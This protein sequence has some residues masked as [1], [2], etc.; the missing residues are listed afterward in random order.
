MGKGIKMKI[1]SKCHL[2]KSYSDFGWFKSNIDNK[3]YIISRCKKC[4]TAR[5]KELYWE[6]KAGMEVDMRV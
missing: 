4:R 1:C 5:S 3:E 6:R 2:F